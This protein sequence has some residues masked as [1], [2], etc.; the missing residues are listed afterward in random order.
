[1]AAVAVAVREDAASG[2]K[3]E[4]SPRPGAGGR[5]LT[6]EEK[7]QLRKEKKLQKKKRKEEK[8]AEPEAGPAVP[9]APGGAGPA[10]ELP[11]TDGQPGPAGRSKAELRA[12]RRAKQEAERALK[13]ARKGEPGRVPPQ[14]APSTTRDPPSGVKPPEHSTA[15]NLTLLKRLK[16]PERQQVPARKDYGAK[17]SLFSHL[18]QYSRQNSLT[19]YMR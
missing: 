11:R 12:E 1:M 4:L 17:V 3:T 9:A 7:L 13:Q 16:R 2:M 14:A 15:D 10:K 8:G 18:P 6:Q 5:E 19:Q